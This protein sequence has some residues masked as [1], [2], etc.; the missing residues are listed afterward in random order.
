MGFSNFFSRFP[1]QFDNLRGGKMRVKKLIVMILLISLSFLQCFGRKKFHQKTTRVQR[2]QVGMLS[3]HR[4][5]LRK[6]KL[7]NKNCNWGFFNFLKNHCY[8]GV[9][10]LSLPIA[11]G[12]YKIIDLTF[13][14]NRPAKVKCDVENKDSRECYPAFIRKQEEMYWCALACIQALLKFNGIEMC[15]KE[16]FSKVSEFP[17]AVVSNGFRVTAMVTCCDFL[18]H[19]NRLLPPHISFVSAILSGIRHGQVQSTKNAFLDFYNRINRNV[20][21]ITDSSYCFGHAV[22]VREIS[23]NEI[24]IEDPWTGKA[25]KQNLDIYCGQYKPSDGYIDVEML[26]TIESHDSPEPIF[27]SLN[28]RAKVKK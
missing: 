9:L 19:I 2:S 14:K 12:G 10:P 15:Q 20:F 1:K 3:S 21:M 25:Y 17:G 11:Y 24:I 23:E 7:S 16:I 5:L 8:L 18:K 4:K 27:Y 22:L 28:W 26:S 13:N 6:R